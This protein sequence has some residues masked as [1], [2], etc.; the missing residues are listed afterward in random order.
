L[1]PLLATALLVPYFKRSTRVKKT[2][3]NP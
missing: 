3:V 2:F 1:F